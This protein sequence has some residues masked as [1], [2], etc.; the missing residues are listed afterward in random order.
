[1][2][3][4][5]ACDAYRGEEP[6]F[7]DL[8]QARG[9][10]IHVINGRTGTVRMARAHARGRSWLAIPGERAVAEARFQRRRRP[11][12]APGRERT[13]DLHHPAGQPHQLTWQHGTDLTMILLAPE[14]LKRMA[15][16][17]GM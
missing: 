11:D 14:L 4:Q 12:S 16:E 6:A 5:T 8:L 1:M 2:M 10:D 9:S 7:T 13:A 3:R 15:H 17:S